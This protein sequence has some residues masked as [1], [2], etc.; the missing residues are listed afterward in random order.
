MKKLLPTSTNAQCKQ[1]YQSKKGFTLVE[2]L[3]VI[4]IIAVLSAVGIVVF[5]GLQKNARDAA[6]RADIDTIS[7]AMEIGYNNTTG[8]YIGLATTMFSGSTFPQDPIRTTTNC[9]ASRVCI[10]CVRSGAGDCPTT[11][12]TEVGALQP[13][14]G[15]T[16]TVCT[17]LEAG[18]NYCRSNQR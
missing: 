4:T 10:Y 16:Y 18:G 9:S 5:G 13:P 15:A 17:N 12:Y 14:A 2:L 3:I 11:G 8:Q 7:K 1:N 6:R